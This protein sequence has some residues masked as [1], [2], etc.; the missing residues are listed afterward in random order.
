MQTFLIE[1]QRAAMAHIFSIYAEQCRTVPTWKPCFMTQLNA[2]MLN[3]PRYPTATQS[4]GLASPRT[5]VLSYQHFLLP[6]IP[7]LIG[8]SAAEGDFRDFAQLICWCCVT[9]RVTSTGG[10]TTASSVPASTPTRQTTGLILDL[11]S[12]TRLC[13]KVS[14]R[15]SSANGASVRNGMHR[16]P[17][18]KNAS[19]C[20]AVFRRC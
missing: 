6:R 8:D 10:C 4:M 9:A 2:L 14:E 3:P 20:K 15:Q 12:Y 1:Q 18:P 17:R 5:L 19:L 7:E 13:A 16:Q 11:N